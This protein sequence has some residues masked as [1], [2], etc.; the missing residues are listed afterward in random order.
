LKQ[1]NTKPKKEKKDSIEDLQPTESSKPELATA[2]AEITKLVEQLNEITSLEKQI[3]EAKEQLKEQQHDLNKKV[4]FK[5]YGVDE[6]K[7]EK[8]NQL[9]FNLQKLD[10][11]KA[12]HEKI[13]DKKEATKSAKAI[14]AIESDNLK[15]TDKLNGLDKFLKSIGGI[16]TTEECKTLILQKHNNLVQSELLKYLNAEKRKLIAGIEKLWD[17]YAVHSQAMEQ[18]RQSTLKKLNKFLTQLNYLN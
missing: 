2:V 14:A 8:K 9:T 7:E 6:E 16:I 4:E 15:I 17:K 11:L 18:E 1:W 10:G 12:R 13:K 5:M 3:K